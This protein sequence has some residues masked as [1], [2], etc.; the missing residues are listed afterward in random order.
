MARARE[1]KTN[2]SGT[3]QVVVAEQT[4]VA[5]LSAP[6]LPFNKLIEDTFG[7]DK[8]AWRS[9]VEA[10]YPNAQTIDSIVLVLSYCKARKLDPMKKPVHI[11]PMYS[12]ALG[13][14]VDTVWPG[15]SEIRT[16][17]ARTGQYAGCDE[18]EFGPPITKTFKGKADKW[19]NQQKTTI[20]VEEKLTFPSW[21][22][23]TVYKMVQGQRVRF[24]GPKVLWL[25]TYATANRF[26]EVPNSMWLERTE[27]QHEK[28]AEAASLRRAFPEEVGNDYAAEEMEGKTISVAQNNELIAQI[29]KDEGPPDPDEPAKREVLT[30]IDKS[31]TIDGEVIENDADEDDD[32]M[33]GDAPRKR[34]EPFKVPC[35]PGTQRADWTNQYLDGFETSE[36]TVDAHKWIDLNLPMLKQAEMNP[37]CKADIKRSQTEVLERTNA[38]LV[39]KDKADKAAKAAEKKNAKADPISTGKPAQDPARSGV[40]AR[41]SKG[42]KVNI[43]PA[44]DPV[45]ALGAAPV[46]PAEWLVWVDKMLATVT[47]PEELEDFWADRI[48]ES[49]GN[50]FP[51]DQTRAL[52]YMDLHEKRLGID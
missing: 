47:V 7:L 41:G 1:N 6:R 14:M 37:Q 44:S 50:Q 40:A 3:R 46:D 51:G 10:Q 25:E 12:S 49:F 45:A 24:V 11:V 2:D 39:I 23:F 22:R 27:G 43:I 26:S 36:T 17:A 19:K 48:A 8:F 20:D 28:C 34:V 52:A 9:L 18:A 35:P 31:Q 4:Q 29:A 30:V 21:C 33:G 32:A 13:K 5:T 38:A 15:I 16:T 42:E